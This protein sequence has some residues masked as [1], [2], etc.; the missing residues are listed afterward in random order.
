MNY[1]NYLTASK[2]AIIFTALLAISSA[3]ADA[4]ADMKKGERIYKL[5]C[6]NCHGRTGDKSALGQSAIIK[7]L[8]TD[9]ILT[10]LQKRK[11][12]EIIGAG[13]IAKERLSEQ[14]MKNIAA[15]IGNK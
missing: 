10:A 1:K 6:S 2:T 4:P 9:E 3:Y 7:D 14:D 5:N 8:K 15:F 13:N 12:G 11:A